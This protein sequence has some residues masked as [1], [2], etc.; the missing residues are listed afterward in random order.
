[1][2]EL[3]PPEQLLVALSAAK[4]AGGDFDIAWTAAFRRMVWPEAMAD[5]KAWRDA[6]EDSRK[7]WRAAFYDRP[8]GWRQRVADMGEPIGDVH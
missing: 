3:E 1:V 2:P 6:L 5:A 8:S 7:E 4:R